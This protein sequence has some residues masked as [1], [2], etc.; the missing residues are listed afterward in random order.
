MVTV[1]RPVV[2]SFA[3]FVGFRRIERVVGEGASG[4]DDKCVVPVGSIEVVL[5]VMVVSDVVGRKGDSEGWSFV[6]KLLSP[7]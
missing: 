6:G 1:D 3:V 7:V 5:I 2:R 4:E